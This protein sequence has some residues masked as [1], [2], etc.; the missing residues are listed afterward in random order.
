MYRIRKHQ[1]TDT[2]QQIT[3]SESDTAS[4]TSDASETSYTSND[5]VKR[6]YIEQDGGEQRYTS[7]VDVNYR[8]PRGGTI[9]DNMRTSEILEKIQG[10]YPLK[11]MK[12]KKILTKLPIFKTWVKYINLKDRK[13]RTGGLLMKVVYPD[14]IMLVNTKL[15]ISWSVQLADNVIYIPDPKELIE[16]ENERKEKQKENDIKDKLYELYL[17]GQLKKV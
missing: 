13:F 9:Q 7:I 6:I 1:T 4:F 8:K 17:N 10:Y 16:M 2:T 11:T 12:E 15:N 14:Y 5:N 3:T